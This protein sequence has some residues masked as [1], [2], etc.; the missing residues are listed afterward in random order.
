WSG[1]LADS[2]KDRAVLDRAAAAQ[3][4]YAADLLARRPEL[5]LVVLAHTH[6]AQLDLRP[7]GRAYLNPG[8]FL[9]GGRYAVVTD[10]AVTLERFGD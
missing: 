9:D 4:T 10:G 3:R 1:H 8:A 5:G 2:T 6:R 7:D